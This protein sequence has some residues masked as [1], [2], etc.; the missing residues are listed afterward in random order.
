V[1]LVVPTIGNVPELRR[2]LESLVVQSFSPLRLLVVDKSPDERVSTLLSEYSDRLEI[3]HLPTPPCGISRAVNTGLEHVTAEVIGIPDDDCW[4]PAGLLHA[5]VGRFA[6]DPGLSGLSVMQLEED[7]RP[8]H[9]RWA[10]GPG[11]VTSTNVWGRGVGPGIFYR[12]VALDAVGPF[13]ETLGVGSGVWEA[14]LET[15][16][17]IR[18]VKAGHRVHF[19]PRLFVFHPGPERGK[20]G[21]YSLDRW[22]SY[23]TAMGHVMRKHRFPVHVALYHCVRPLLGA[24]IALGAGDVTLARRRLATARGRFAGWLEPCHVPMHDAGLSGASTSSVAPADLPSIDLVVPTLGRPIELRR[25]LDSIVLQAYPSVRVI[26]VNMDDDDVS[27]DV[28]GEF[29]GSLE[30]L[31]LRASRRGV[32]KAKNLALASTDADI[33][34]VADD[35]CWY[36]PG[37]LWHVGERF[38]RMPELAGLSIMQVDEHLRPSNGRWARHAG[39]ITRTNVW[40]R[41]VAAGM[42]FRASALEGVGPFDET[43]GRASGVWEAGEET[44]ILIRIVDAGHRVDYDP[45]L[46]VH[47]PDPARDSA[48]SYSPDRWRGYACAM[49]HVMRKHHYPL[50]SVAYR[51]AR[52]LLGSMVAALRGDLRQ[53]RIRLAVAAGRA[54]GWARSA[55]R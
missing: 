13:D 16:L 55:P 27:A 26:V 54:E 52:P 39:Q 12:R 11:R 1:D 14:G 22:R 47:H 15:D 5:V 34:S 51:C 35:D 4:Y 36:P 48:A 40:G 41:G 50:H 53:A 44:D 3:L 21:A 49:G 8:S 6:A 31:H 25:L 10:R 24:P 29:S 7:G 9:G 43:L 33:V 38:V 45:S 32:S 2:L 20:A 23:G 19:E 30:I 46:C 18:L 28:L 42:F 37:L 17:L